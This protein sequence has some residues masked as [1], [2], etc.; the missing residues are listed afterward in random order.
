ML[1]DDQYGRRRQDGYTAG[2]IDFFSSLHLS[3]ET[4]KFLFSHAGLKPECLWANKKREIALDQ[5]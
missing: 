2:H 3:F 4:D 5:G 1:T